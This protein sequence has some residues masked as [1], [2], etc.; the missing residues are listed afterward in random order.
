MGQ[1]TSKV[2]FREQQAEL[3]LQVVKGDGP[4]LLGRDWLTE[5][6]LDWEKIKVVHETGLSGVLNRHH[7]LFQPGLETFQGHKARIVVN[8]QAKPKY[9]KA[10]LV[11]YAF[12]GMV[13]AELQGL[14]AE[15]I[16]E[17]VEFAEWASPIVPV[18]KR[19]KASVRICGDFKQTVN[20][21]S[22]LDNYPIPHVED[23]FASLVGGK[24]FS[25]LD[26]KQAYIHATSGGG[27]IKAICCD[28][29]PKGVV[30]IHSATLWHFF[31]TRH[32]PKSNG[33]PVAG[34]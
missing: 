16:L 12:R 31:S 24:V 23:L 2:K 29:H 20:P 1:L 10:R 33:E 30:L 27:G 11:P 22:R 3:T 15:G 6:R 21:V 5:I 25:K 32:I 34:D 8:P 7:Q 14:V 18:L 26:L 28:Q 17:P 9:C 13:E 4:S 19:D